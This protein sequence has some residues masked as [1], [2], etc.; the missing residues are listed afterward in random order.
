MNSGVR[1]V[2]SL[3]ILITSNAIANEN[4]PDLIGLTEIPV[5]HE[6]MWFELIENGGTREKG[7]TSQVTLFARPNDWHSAVLVIEDFSSLYS[8]Y[9]S[10]KDS[11]KAHVYNR[12]P[13]WN[14]L[15]T[16]DNQLLW[17]PETD[18][19]NFIGYLDVLRSFVFSQ[20]PWLSLNVNPIPDSELVEL[21]EDILEIDFFRVHESRFVNGELWLRLKHEWH[22]VLHEDSGISPQD[23]RFEYSGWVRAHDPNGEPIFLTLGPMC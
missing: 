15:K 11:L 7:D 8:S 9:I 4:K 21:H 5:I 17:I 19:S 3:L 14:Q 20:P 22:V 23:D 6:P 18:T 1:L 13:G 12:V 16:A 2:I 10:H